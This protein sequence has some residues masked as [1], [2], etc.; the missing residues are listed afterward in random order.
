MSTKQYRG[1]GIT[2]SFT[3]N[4]VKSGFYTDVFLPHKDELILGVRRNYVNL[5]YNCDSI[6]KLTMHR[7]GLKADINAFYLNGKHS[8]SIVS[9]SAQEMSSA[10]EYIVQHSKTK[11]TEEKQAQHRLV[12]SNNNNPESSWYC[13]DVEYKKGYDSIDERE[14][15]FQGRFDI[16]AISKK[17]PFRI[18]IIELKYGSGAIGGNSGIRKHI[19]DFYAFNGKD[20]SGVSYYK[21]FQ[22]EVLS[23]LKAEINLGV[24]VPICLHGIDATMFAPHPEFYVITLDNNSY[25]NSA[26]PLQTMSGYL[27]ADKRWGCKKVSAEVWDNGDYFELIHKDKY[28]RPILLFS[29]QTLDTLS[30]DDILETKQYDTVI[31]K[32]DTFKEIEETRQISLIENSSTKWIFDDAK[33]RGLASWIDDKSRQLKSG[34]SRKVLQSHQRLCNLYAG[35]RDE[36]PEYFA[37]NK[38][39]WWHMAAESDSEVSAHLASSQVACLNH[40]FSIRNDEKAILSILENATGLEFNSVLPSLDDPDSLLSFEFVYHNDELLQEDDLGAGRGTM[41]TSVDAFVRAKHN[42]EIWLF[43][44]EWKYTESYAVEDKTNPTRLHR[45]QSLIEQSNYLKTPV[46]GIPHSIY[47]QEPF[48]ELMRQTLLSEQMIRNGIAAHMFHLCV[49]PDGNADLRIGISNSYIPMLKDPSS[50]KLIS[51]ITLVSP[52]KRSYRDL[53]NYLQT[54]YW[55]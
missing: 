39:A 14:N 51:P 45:Y 3:C 20:K 2:E 34:P 53:I 49:V 42:D 15:N 33:N 36:A 19:S 21:Q 16:L 44:I 47:F 17:A 9:I 26:T 50:F 31:S 24:D 40:L 23:I 29:N 4:F 48:Y 22:D 12:V 10:F 7:D 37:K 30:I 43:P 5:Y 35:I 38:I 6:G 32:I 11:L 13:F 28:F 27:F 54:R 41:C 1:V 18:A 55:N 25:N 8:Q 46:D 52:L